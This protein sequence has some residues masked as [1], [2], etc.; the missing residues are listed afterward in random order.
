[1]KFK[2]YV[3]LHGMPVGE[4]VEITV[5]KHWPSTPEP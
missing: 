4:P 3:E 2:D 1:M 5:V